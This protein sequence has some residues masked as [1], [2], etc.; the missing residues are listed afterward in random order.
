MDQQTERM[1]RSYLRTRR[2]PGFS[3]L[4]F[5]IGVPVLPLVIWL[6][7]YLERH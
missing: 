3:A 6:I 2:A 5:L 1:I 7:G 4:F